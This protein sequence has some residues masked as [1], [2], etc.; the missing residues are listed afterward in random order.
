ML[1]LIQLAEIMG[2]DVRQCLNPSN[3]EQLCMKSKNIAQSLPS[4]SS[5]DLH[6]LP[7]RAS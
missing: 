2:L 7:P 5:K 6:L 1:S 4:P 3:Y